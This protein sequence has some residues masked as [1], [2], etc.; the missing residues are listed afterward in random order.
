MASNG[1]RLA[2]FSR[3]QGAEAMRPSCDDIE[4]TGKSVDV[5]FY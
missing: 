2:G 5:L 4:A 3:L 1:S